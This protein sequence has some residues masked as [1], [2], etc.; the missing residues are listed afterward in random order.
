[1]NRLSNLTGGAFLGAE[2][3]K[4]LNL[5]SNKIGGIALEAFAPLK[6][7]EALRLDQ[8]ELEDI[9]GLLTGQN[10]LQVWSL[11]QT[12]SVCFY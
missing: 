4:M 3:L 2:G 7:L 8:N 11:M 10:G 9:N 1:M 6:K 5:A 12:F